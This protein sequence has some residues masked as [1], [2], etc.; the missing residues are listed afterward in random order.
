MYT[1][2]SSS[3]FCHAA[4]LEQRLLDPEEPFQ[5][6]HASHAAMAMQLNQKWAANSCT[7]MMVLDEES[8]FRVYSI[9]KKMTMKY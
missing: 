1:L 9:N 2:S 8:V 5:S 4:L 7:Y 6:H 3:G